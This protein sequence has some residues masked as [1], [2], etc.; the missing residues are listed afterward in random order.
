MLKDLCKING[1]LPVEISKLTGSEWISRQLCVLLHVSYPRGNQ[2]G[3]Q[4]V[5]RQSR[6]KE[7]VSCNNRIWNEHQRQ[8]SCDTNTPCFDGSNIDTLAWQNEE[9][10]HAALAERHYRRNVGPMIPGNFFGK[11]NQRY[12]GR[13]Y[14]EETGVSC[15]QT[16]ANVQ[17]TI[18]CYL[19]SVAGLIDKIVLQWSA[20]ISIV[21]GCMSAHINTDNIDVVLD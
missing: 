4:H 3:F 5:S 16:F 12:A 15:L 11:L 1:N 13:V 14:I 19:R 9:M 21:L 20:A 2:V 10:L 7:T 6:I 8:K 17:Y 18:L